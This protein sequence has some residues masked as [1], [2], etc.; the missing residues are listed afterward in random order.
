MSSLSFPLLLLLFLPSPPSSL[1][2][3][4]DD[5]LLLLGYDGND[6][7]DGDDRPLS[8]ENPS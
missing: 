2:L 3:P 1:T 8:D 4:G 5:I 7:R 6:G